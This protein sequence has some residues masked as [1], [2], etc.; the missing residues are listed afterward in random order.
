MLRSFAVLT[1]C[2]A[3]APIAVADPA[4]HAFDVTGT[5]ASN[6]GPVTLH[7]HGAIVT[8]EYEFDGGHLDG[9][10]DGNLLRYTWHERAGSGHGVFVVA[11]NGELIGTWGVGANDLSGGGWRL[12]PR[13]HIA[14]SEA[15][16]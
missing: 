10:L 8:G 6:W 11:T 14:A 15:T 1:T 13:A 4:P 16:P 12:T 9:K 3:T 2:L 5:Y 7:Q